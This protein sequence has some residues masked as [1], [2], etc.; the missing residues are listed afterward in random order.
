MSGAADRHADAIAALRRAV[1]ETWGAATLDQRAAT[2]SAAPT[3]TAADA[4]LEKVRHASY[5]IVDADIDAL[6]TAGMTEDAV[7]ELTLAAALGEATR[8]FDRSMRALAGEA[9]EASLGAAPGAEA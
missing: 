6:R 4:C 3:G 7:F 8:T 5:R 1:L 2:E 9:P